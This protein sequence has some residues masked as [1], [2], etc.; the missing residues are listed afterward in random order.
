MFEICF[1]TKC[2]LISG[3]RNYSN[4]LGPWV[5]GRDRQEEELG[6]GQA[7]RLVIHVWAGQ[8]QGGVHTVASA[9]GPRHLNTSSAQAPPVVS[10]CP[11]L[12]DRAR[13]PHLALPPSKQEGP[14]YANMQID[15]QDAHMATRWEPTVTTR[16][17][18]VQQR[19]ISHGALSFLITAKAFPMDHWIDTSH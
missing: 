2:E 4:C 1:C 8:R 13:K 5:T 9:L 11:H 15:S 12:Y 16:D 19:C 7:A 6:P 3:V 14:N 17:I 18:S 10:S